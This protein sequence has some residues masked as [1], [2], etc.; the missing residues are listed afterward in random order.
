MSVINCR[1]QNFLQVSFFLI[2]K[3]IGSNRLLGNLSETSR[4]FCNIKINLTEDVKNELKKSNVALVIIPKGLTRILQP[5]DT[6]INKIIKNKFK[7][8]YFATL[9]NG[10]TNKIT[11]SELINW[12][13]NTWM[14]MSESYKVTIAN[15]FISC[16]ISFL[17]IFL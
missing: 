14:S 13:E 15:S 3:K 4:K 8:E 6:T 10:R 7:E 2:T 16:G 12:V 17:Y 11:R 1:N 9:E 5:I